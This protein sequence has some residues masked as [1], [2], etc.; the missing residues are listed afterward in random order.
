MY[1]GTLHV[2]GDHDLFSTTFYMYSDSTE[3]N[4]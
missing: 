4:V 2:L 1:K 3:E